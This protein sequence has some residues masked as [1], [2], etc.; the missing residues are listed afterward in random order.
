MR[1][2][3]MHREPSTGFLLTTPLRRGSGFTAAQRAVLGTLQGAQLVVNT[4]NALAARPDAA[5]IR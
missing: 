4:I 5:T 1:R 2:I 3:A